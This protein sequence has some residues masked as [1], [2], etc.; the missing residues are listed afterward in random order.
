MAID[1]KVGKS[2]SLGF[3]AMVVVF[4]HSVEASVEANGHSKNSARFRICVKSNIPFQDTLDVNYWPDYLN[5]YDKLGGYRHF[6]V[7]IQQ[8]GCYEFDLNDVKQFGTL[9]VISKYV[10]GL[11]DYQLVEPGDV[12][13]ASCS[14]RGSGAADVVFSGK[15]AEKYQLAYSNRFEFSS[16]NWKSLTDRAAMYS[17][18]HKLDSGVNR[19]L[20]ILEDTRSITPAI[21]NV[22]RLNIVAESQQEFLGAVSYRYSKGKLEL[23]AEVIGDLFSMPAW[24]E[25][26]DGWIKYHSRFFVRYQY[27]LTKLKM[28]VQFR[29][30]PEPKPNG[31]S[32]KQFYQRLRDSFPYPLRDKLMAYCLVEPVDIPFFFFGCQPEEYTAMLKDAVDLIQV[33]GMNGVLRHELDTRAMGVPAYDFELPDS[34]GNTVSLHDLRGKILMIEM[35][36]NPCGGCRVFNQKFEAQVFPRLRDS[37]DFAVV[38]INL[39]KEKERWLAGWAEHTSS[40]YI[41]LFTAG[42]GFD[43]PLARHYNIMGVPFLLLIDRKGN[44][45]SSTLNPEADGLYDL[46]M[47]SVQAPK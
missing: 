15:G 1:W 27:E 36:S 6:R 10:E 26:A 17:L 8:G 23:D 42:K 47:R 21:R 43:H 29:D 44:I 12:I 28:R 2:V 39:N 20:K 31:F 37:P 41:N 9:L 5:G 33:P 13:T 35:W 45:I 32:L 38:S 14:Y 25:K 24:A 40:E 7:P 19:Q 18:K 11:M 16:W 30:Q 22:M 3:L 34:S 4:A 46:I